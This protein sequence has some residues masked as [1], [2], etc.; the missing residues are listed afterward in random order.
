M[1]ELEIQTLSETREGLL[2]D[3]GGIVVATGFT[4]LRQRLAQD[5]MA[6]C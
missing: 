6:R 5:P 3:V 4:L 1:I 2:I